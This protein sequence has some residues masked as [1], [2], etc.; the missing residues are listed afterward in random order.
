MHDVAGFLDALRHWLYSIFDPWNFGSNLSA[1]VVQF[2]L[3]LAVVWFARRPLRRLV[4]RLA[5]RHLSGHFASHLQQVEDRLAGHKDDTVAEIK[6]HVT[7]ELAVIRK[8]LG[9][10]D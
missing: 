1:A 3:V 8:H 7:A 10:G 9:I 4:D 6:A 2:A 5:H